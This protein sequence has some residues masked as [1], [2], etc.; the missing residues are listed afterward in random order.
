[1]EEKGD[2]TMTLDIASDIIAK[3]IWV[4]II[5]SMPSVA[6]GLLAGLL[7]SIFQAVTQIQEQTLTFVPKMVVIL[8][9]IALTF[10]WMANYVL[11]F[12]VHLWENIPT[13]SK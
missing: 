11:D 1:M 12:S 8:L 7:V 6:L 13:Y 3:A 5:V 10:S 9:V 2:P 4:I